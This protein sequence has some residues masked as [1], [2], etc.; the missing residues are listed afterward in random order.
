MALPTKDAPIKDWNFD[1]KITNQPDRGNQ[2]TVIYAD[3]GGWKTTLASYAANPIILPVYLETGAKVSA[4]PRF[5]NVGAD[6]NPVHHVFAA[7][8]WL[9]DEKHT[10]KTLVID[11]LS[12]YRAAV[13]SDVIQDLG[14][15]A[16]GAA[17]PEYSISKFSYPYY[18]RLLADISRLQRKRDM[19][20]III[21]H[22]EKY[23]TWVD[24]KGLDRVSASAISG[25]KTNAV[26]LIEG[27]ADNFYLIRNEPIT[28][29][30]EEG[31]ITK[32]TV[33]K[34]IGQGK[35]ILYTAPQQEFFAKNRLFFH[36]QKSYELKPNDDGMALKFAK[37]E[38]SF[39][40]FWRDFYD[41]PEYLPEP[42]RLKPKQE[43]TE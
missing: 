16:T 25:E 7:I 23:T 32:K 15:T 27:Q 11:N 35:T 41:N 30:T 31:G 8:K 43:K 29:S 1:L 38:Q 36:M 24:G 20:V 42:T 3:G 22:T 6:Q 33:Q 18:G 39:I 10:R 9:T 13:Q 4:C 12:N 21:A 40:D 26:K 2:L 19:D 34:V 5:P 37:T 28:R 17:Q 14:K